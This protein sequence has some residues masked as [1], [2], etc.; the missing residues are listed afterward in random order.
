MIGAAA[1]GRDAGV[2]VSRSS[3]PCLTVSP[4]LCRSGIRI[5]GDP[6]PEEAKRE[7]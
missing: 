1:E 6:D 3:F 5:V 2:P 7:A 4:S